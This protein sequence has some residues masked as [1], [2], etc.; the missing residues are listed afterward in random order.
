MKT[1][2]KKELVHRIAEKTGVTKVVAKEVIQSFLNSIIDELAE[3]NR[4]EFRE[5][6]V[7]ESRERAA[8]LAQNPRT[9]EKVPVPAKRI[10]KFKVGRLMR[11][12]VSGEDVG[13]LS[14]EDDDD[15]DTTAAHPR[16]AVG[17]HEASGMA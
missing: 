17:G 11:K 16:G 5:F 13:G 6:G 7:F 3:G 12:K 4:L 2:T 10:V 1:V 14:L 8:R 9:L 15:D